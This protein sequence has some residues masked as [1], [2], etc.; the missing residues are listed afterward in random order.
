[1][2]CH[3]RKMYVFRD[4]KRLVSTG[5]LVAGLTK[6]LAKELQ[7]S[8]TT[9]TSKSDSETAVPRTREPKAQICGFTKVSLILA[10]N[11]LSKNR[12]F[13]FINRLSVTTLVY[14]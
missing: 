7:L 8:K 14:H 12:S 11:R 6:A 9:Q 3:G 2:N 4:G 10:A 5:R 1:M 13:F